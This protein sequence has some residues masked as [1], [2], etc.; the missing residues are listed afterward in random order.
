[1]FL[2]AAAAHAQLLQTFYVP[3]P[4]TQVR[5][6]A[7]AIQDLA[8]NEN[9]NSV[10]SIT[11]TTDGTVIHYDQ[12]ENGFEADLENPAVLFTGS[13]FD[14]G[15]PGT[16]IWGDGDLT[17]GCPP[18]LNDQPNLCT[19]AT[20]DQFL[21]GDVIVLENS[22]PL[23]PTNTRNPSDVRFDGGDKFASTQLLAV[24]R[25][26]WPSTGV[27]AQLGGAVEVFDTSEWATPTRLR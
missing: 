17:N 13:P 4:E 20:D 8:E 16:Q 27:Q 7:D 2:S 10:I 19:V 1:M 26:A 14:P 6:W 21:A 3:L 24:T 15:D 5:I 12:W 9:M 25:A 23:G 22:V 11:I 18:N